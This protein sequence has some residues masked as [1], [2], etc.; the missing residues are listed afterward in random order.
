MAHPLTIST[1]GVLALLG[2]GAG[3]HLGYSAIAEINPIYYSEAQ[4]RFHADLSPYSRWDAAPEMMMV[5]AGDPAPRSDCVGCRTYPEEYYPIHDASI[6]RY[7]SSYARDADAALAT[8][9]VEL[10]EEPEPEALRLREDIQKVERFAR[11]AS[12][13]P[14]VYASAEAEALEDEAQR[15][16]LPAED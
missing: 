16:E 10:P 12:D 1:V 8:A 7:S 9:A 5:N 11:G 4:T 6:D 2:V 14:I 13:T 3:V 15:A